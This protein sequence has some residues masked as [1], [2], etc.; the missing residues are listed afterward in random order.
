MSQKGSA[1]GKALR[2]REEKT[3]ATSSLFSSKFL[4]G[5]AIAEDSDQNT[6]AA[7]VERTSFRRQNEL[8]INPLGQDAAR[9]EAKH[10]FV[11]V[12]TDN[13]K[14]RG[15]IVAALTSLRAS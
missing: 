14:R 12:M 13:G 6:G 3:R 11:D 9:L 5:V 4:T 10:F 8:H 1:T 15:P 2:R 7:A